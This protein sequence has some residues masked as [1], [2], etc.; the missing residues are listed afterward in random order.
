MIFRDPN[1]LYKVDKSVGQ[2]THINKSGDELEIS[3]SVDISPITQYG[4]TLI[5]VLDGANRFITSINLLADGE[6]SAIIKSGNLGK[7]NGSLII[8]VFAG[9]E[10]SGFIFP[11]HID[12]GTLKV[13]ADFA[14]KFLP[15]GS[16][17]VPSFRNEF[18]ELIIK[19]TKV[20]YVARSIFQSIP[21]GNNY[22]TLDL[23]HTERLGGRPS[24][25][26]YLFQIDFQNK[27]VL[28]IG[29]NT[30]ENSRIARKLG[31]SLVDGF[32]YDPFFVEIGR[33]INAVAGMTRVSLFQGDCTMPQL[34]VGMKYDLVLALAVWVYLQ[35]TMKNIAEIT[36]TMIFE[37]HT[38]D[39]GMGFYYSSVLPYFPYAIALG[40]TDKPK[41]P[42]KSRMFL[43]FGKNREKLEQI[44]QRKFLVVKP[45][46]DNQF[47]K[48][49][50]HL[51]KT[52]ILSLAEKFLAK[53]YNP[54]T[55][56]ANDYRFG[57][58]TYYEV[59]LAGLAQ[60]LKNAE[61]VDVNNIYVNFLK[62]G[63][64]AGIIDPALANF[65]ENDSWLYRKVANKYDDAIHII[66]GNVDFVLPV[67]IVPN[68]KGSLTFTTITGE[69]IRCDIFDGHHRFF[70]CEL[71]GAE[72]IH[73]VR[74]GENTSSIAQR[75]SQKI[76][77]NY[78]LKIQ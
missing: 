5:V 73:Y 8:Q 39:H 29:A 12:V 17:D 46:F 69:N 25:E 72:K 50:N 52:E 9:S 43:L 32:E 59:F 35:D 27:T 22:Q 37:T 60:Y 53:H 7:D 64:K 57:A 28:D 61:K 58:V 48:S 62:Q 74:Y 3:G 2:I 75:F 76:A 13:Y 23:G 77:S 45:Y 33:A 66:N 36:D 31:A 70:M 20:P 71:A 34:Y 18:R 24:R 26:N 6:W 41:D 56:T 55:Y 51:S 1:T 78:T 15:E 11:L 67:E 68:T 14:K 38:L 4:L 40:L 16:K 47:I 63:I 21:T 49:Y 42:H 54:L 30:G 19:A 44:I 65:T 10:S